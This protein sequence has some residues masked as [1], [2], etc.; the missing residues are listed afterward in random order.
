MLIEFGSWFYLVMVIS[1]IVAMFLEAALPRTDRPTSAHH[2]LRNFG[3]WMV[4]FYCADFLVGTYWLDIQS[5][6]GQQAFGLLYWFA[7]PRDWMLVLAGVLILDLSDYFFHRLEHRV[8]WLWRFHSVHHTD[9]TMDVSTTLRTHPVS[10][11]LSNFWRIGTALAFGLPLWLIAFRELLIFPL[12]F[13]QHANVRLPRHWES[14]FGA[15]F[16]TPGIHHNHH[17]E[18][19]QE[20]DS[21]YGDGLVVWDKLFGTYTPPLMDGSLRY[22][23]VNR[24]EEEFQSIEGMLLT[25]FKPDR[26]R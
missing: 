24:H 14:L 1:I 19:R 6:L 8:P 17:A 11:V 13:I 20:H 10:M 23:L 12:L 22:G 2:M 4:S 21:N 18:R 3:L 26:Q 7:L 15:V 16:I 5:M 9:N 25:P